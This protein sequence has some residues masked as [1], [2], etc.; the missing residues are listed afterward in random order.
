MVLP[1]ERVVSNANKIGRFHG[2]R[3]APDHHACTYYSLPPH[4]LYI[5][6]FCTYSCDYN[7]HHYYH[8]IKCSTNYILL[9]IDFKKT[10]DIDCQE[11]D[12]QNRVL[13]F[14]TIHKYCQPVNIMEMNFIKL[15]Y[16][17]VVGVVV[18]HE[19]VLRHG[20]EAQAEEGREAR[21]EARAR[22]QLTQ[23]RLVI[24]EPLSF[25]YA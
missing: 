3:S 4:Y 22:Y 15:Y 23:H 10:K 17:L 7:K 2:K 20:D 25:E 9:Q 8:V 13:N 11:V 6:L 5:K 12:W 16:D 24:K 19:E 14:S 21:C 1:I 18:A